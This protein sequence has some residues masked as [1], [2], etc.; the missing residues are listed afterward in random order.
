M[1]ELPKKGPEIVEDAEAIRLRELRQERRELGVLSHV[2]PKGRERRARLDA[3]I[4]EIRKLREALVQTGG[5][6]AVVTESQEQ[7]PGKLD[8]LRAKRDQLMTELGVLPAWR[9]LAKSDLVR[10]IAAIDRQ[11]AEVF[12]LSRT[13]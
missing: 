2:F 6:E 8:M 12:N 5:S 10:R 11:T 4:A 9:A 7:K 1:I 3:E 13:A